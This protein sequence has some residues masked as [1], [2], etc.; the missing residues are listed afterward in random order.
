L[1]R[2]DPA[3]GD[4]A[5]RRLPNGFISQWDTWLQHSIATSRAQLAE[6]W[7]DLYLTSPI[8]RFALLPG[9]CGEH[10]WAGVLMPSVDKVGR[11]FP[12]TLAVALAPPLSIASILAAH[13]WYAAIEGVAL[14]A[15]RLDGSLDDLEQDLAQHPFPLSPTLDSEE[16]SALH[17][18][19][20]WWQ[21]PLSDPFTLPLNSAVQ[22]EELI[23]ATM[24]TLFAEASRGKS[25]WWSCEADSGT[26]ALHCCTGLPPHEHLIFLLHS[27]SQPTMD[28]LDI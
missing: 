6:R 14:S 5:S 8:W 17:A 13:D 2:Q 23:S 25:L 10:A 27:G 28:P 4:F 3:L 20:Q 9:V 16:Q 21:S 11:H 7:L 12:L 18:L 1:V 26:G 19:A 24:S 15:L 22:V